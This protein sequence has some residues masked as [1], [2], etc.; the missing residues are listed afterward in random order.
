[1]LNA[2]VLWGAGIKRKM[3]MYNVLMGIENGI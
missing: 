1:M 3:L 2:C